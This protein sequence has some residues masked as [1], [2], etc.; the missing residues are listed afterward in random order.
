ML[1]KPN[2]KFQAIVEKTYD[3][4]FSPPRYEAKARDLEILVRG[5]DYRIPYEDGE[6]AVTAWGDSDRPAVLLMHGWGG[7][8]A[9]MTGLVDPLVSSGFRVVAYD[10]PAHG[11][12]DGTMSTILQIAPT[13]EL[14]RR[15]EGEFDAII[16]HSFGTLVTSYAVARLGFPPPSHLVYLGAFN[17]AF[18]AL[19]RFQALAKLPDAVMDGFRDLLYERFGRESLD[20][21]VN[22]D[23]ASQIAVPALL[24]HDTADDVTSIAHS[25]AIARKWGTSILIETNGL[26]HRGALQSAEIHRQIVRFIKDRP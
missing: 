24:F 7:A 18:D 5:G 22:E 21:I 8:R 25:H 4:F 14:V 15:H 2:P 26:G 11:D 23:L 10:Q 13:M 1:V 19:P 17:R 3:A 6:L 20:E 12:S 16:A 9:Q